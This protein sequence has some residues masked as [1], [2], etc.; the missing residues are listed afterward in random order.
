VITEYSVPT[1]GSLSGD[2]KAGPDGAL[3]FS[4]YGK[5]GRIATSGTITEYALPSGIKGTPDIAVGPDDALW[6]G[7]SKGNLFY[8]GICGFERMTTRGSFT[9]YPTH[10]CAANGI[11]T[12]P[13]HALW[14]TD[15][16][17]VGR[18]SLAGAVTLYSI[19]TAESDP[20]AITTGPGG[21]LWF[22]E[23]GDGA[24]P[25]PGGNNIGRITISGSLTEYP[26][27][28]N[29]SHPR[30]IAVGT[31]AAVWF[32]ELSGNKIGRLKP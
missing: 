30:G 22:A 28:A 31:D 19:P 32:T 14:F 27:P 9:F 3:W 24:E 12:G 23:F 6:V 20:V 15:G 25:N 16:G 17:G 8:G 13:D 10:V 1:A 4:E 2:I 7:A 21:A 26:L 18:M 11:T 29:D 5:I